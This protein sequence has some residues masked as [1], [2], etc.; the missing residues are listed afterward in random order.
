MIFRHLDGVQVVR[1]VSCDGLND[2]GLA[3]V[4]K[5]DIVDSIAARIDARSYRAQ[6]L[7]LVDQAPMVGLS[8]ASRFKCFAV[9][10]TAEMHLHPGEGL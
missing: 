6:P 9:D 2:V 5:A 10:P 4:L 7:G 8:V 3:I 1:A